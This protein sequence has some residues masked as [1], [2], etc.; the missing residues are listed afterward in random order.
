MRPL[1]TSR[2]GMARVCAYCLVASNGA[3]TS[4]WPRQRPCLW[5]RQKAPIKSWSAQEAVTSVLCL[6]QPVMTH[7]YD[8]RHII[9]IIS[10]I[11]TVSRST[12][13]SYNDAFKISAAAGD[14]PKKA[15]PVILF[16]Q[17]IPVSA[18]LMYNYQ[19]HSGCFHSISNSY[20]KFAC[21]NITFT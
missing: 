19:G 17:F 11:S 13:R 12:M 4:W 14:H 18:P 6:P 10:N 2:P 20:W 7:F 21:S 3:N 5:Q 8:S 9:S 16:L 1:S 15:P